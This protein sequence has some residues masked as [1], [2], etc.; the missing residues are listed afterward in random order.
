MA[1]LRTS[2]STKTA[3]TARRYSQYHTY[4][5]PNH[6]TPNQHK[7][8]PHKGVAFFFPTKSNQQNKTIWISH[9]HLVNKFS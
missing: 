5:N 8:H 3:N 6:I 9:P 1:L 4:T 7:S 2:C